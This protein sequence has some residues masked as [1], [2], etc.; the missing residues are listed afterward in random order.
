MP[1]STSRAR[2][3]TMIASGAL[4]AA[5]AAALSLAGC[6]NTQPG[7]VNNGPGYTNNINDLSTK[8]Q[9]YSADPCRSAQSG[10]LFANCGRFVTEVASTI[11]TLRSQL[12]NNADIG[13][14]QNA[15]NSFQR[16]GCDAIGG[17]PTAAQRTG[18]PQALLAI[19]HALDD[20]NRALAKTTPT[21]PS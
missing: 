2:R 8:V 3:R 9:V 14:A 20:L 12:P 5:L 16:L 4:A 10:Q 19:G 7:D 6:A 18:C 15:V 13:A 1:R 21:T 17:T 11:G